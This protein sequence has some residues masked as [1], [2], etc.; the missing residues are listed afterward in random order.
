MYC[1]NARNLSINIE[2]EHIFYFNPSPEGE[3][4]EGIYQAEKFHCRR[5]GQYILLHRKRI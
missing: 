2:T 5:D 3:G 1:N 4:G